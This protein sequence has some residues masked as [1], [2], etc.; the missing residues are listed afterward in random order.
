[1]SP[2]VQAVTLGFRREAGPWVSWSALVAVVVT[3]V[4]ARRGAARG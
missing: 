2:L 4:V 3:G 1:M